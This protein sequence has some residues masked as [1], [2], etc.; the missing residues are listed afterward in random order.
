MSTPTQNSRELPLSQY[1]L[2][3]YLGRVRHAAEL[4]DP[5]TLFASK[6]DIKSAKE[7]I[8][9]YKQNVVPEMTPELWRAKRMLDS[10]L[11]PDTGETIFFPFRMSCY[12]FSNFI[13]TVGM[14]A[15]GLGASGTLFWQI[16]NQT[17]NVA[18]NFSNANKSNSISRRDLMKSYLLA[19]SASCSVALGLRSLVPRLKSLS[20]STRT[21]LSRLVPFS[22]VASASALNVVLMRYGEIRDGIDVFP[23]RPATHDNLTPND[24]QRDKRETL[25]KSRKAAAIAVAETAVSRVINCTPIMA[26]TPLIYYRLQGTKFLRAHPSIAWPVNLALIYF[27]SIIT[28]PFSLGVFPQRQ[29]ISI[30]R[31][32]ERFREAHPHTKIVEFNRGM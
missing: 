15:P 8:A 10:T 11:H 4:T 3:T 9:S 30:D 12:V 20:P 17:L 27:T 14:L 19:V 28:L 1:D 22:A 25:G 31:L 7:L 13:V 24:E 16:T 32:E 2:S 18:I 6:S 23:A 5:R 26:M 21:I 29:S